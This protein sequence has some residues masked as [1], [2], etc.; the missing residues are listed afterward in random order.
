MTWVS[1]LGTL[2]TLLNLEKSIDAVE[3]ES[4]RRGRLDFLRHSDPKTFSR[5]S[6]GQTVLWDSRR[7]LCRRYIRVYVR[8][9]RLS[10]TDGSCMADTGAFVEFIYFTNS[11]ESAPMTN[12]QIRLFSNAIQFFCLEISTILPRRTQLFRKSYFGFC[13]QTKPLLRLQLVCIGS[14]CR[15][16]KRFNIFI[17]HLK[18]LK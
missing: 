8:V 10:G 15:N 11:Y 14:G 16:F 6:V 5:L 13:L 9:C 12:Q 4:S 1:S 3:V 7:H 18:L 2:C 17:V